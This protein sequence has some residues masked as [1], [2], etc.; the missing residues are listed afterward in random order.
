MA[1]GGRLLRSDALRNGEAPQCTLGEGFGPALPPV[2]VVPSQ[3][4][5]SNVQIEIQLEELEP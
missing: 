1:A 4:F 5:P 2:P 3:P